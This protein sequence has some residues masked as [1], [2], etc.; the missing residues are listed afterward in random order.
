MLRVLFN[1]DFFKEARYRRVKCPAELVAGLVKLTGIYGFP[2]LG[3]QRLAN[4]T[5]VMGQKLMD[6]PTVEG[7]HTGREWI[8]GGTLTERVNFSAEL[9]GDASKPGTA[10][11]V[12]RVC[13]GGRIT[14]EDIVERCLEELGPVEPTDQTRTALIRHAEEAGEI[15]FETEADREAVSARVARILQLIVATKEYQFA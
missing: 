8:D 12:E 10:A 6:P 4:A 11:L 3:I 1:S 14:P 2:D 9:I 13:S 7:W 5:T 15:T